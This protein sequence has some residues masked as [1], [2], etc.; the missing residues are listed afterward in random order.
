M[1]LIR[2]LHEFIELLNTENVRYLLI[3]GWAFN[4]YAEPRFTGDIDFF[5]SSDPENQVRL[6]K[7][8]ERFGFGGNLPLGN[9]F[10]KP[11]IMLGRP[12]HRIDL[13]V[14]VDGIGF[15]EA[16]SSRESDEL[17]GLQVPF[18]SLEHLIRNKKAAGR[19]KDLADVVALETM[20]KPDHSN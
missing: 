15:E 6:R 8:L 16:W 3:G 18:I 20:K 5:C 7:V 2:D 17:D 1:K 10:E 11:I 9:L 4:R 13:I 14:Q 12:P 19:P